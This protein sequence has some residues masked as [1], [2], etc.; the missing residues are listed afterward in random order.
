MRDT[1]VDMSVHPFLRGS[2]ADHYPGD[3]SPSSRPPVAPLL[4]AVLVI[5]MGVVLFR[6]RRDNATMRAEVDHGTQAFVFGASLPALPV[7]DLSSGGGTE[8]TLNTFCS[9]GHYVLAVFR[10]A[11]CPRCEELDAS[12]REIAARRKDA[13]VVVI[14]VRDSTEV[15]D[16]QPRPISD[17]VTTRGALH[18]SLHIGVLPAAILVDNQC[19]EIAAA[20]GVHGATAVVAQLGVDA[21]E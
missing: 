4:L 3:A 17:A 20:V 5:A 10:P 8:R 19:H 13:T 7:L 9:A 6:A 18:G 15:R 16:P 12:Y 2:M 1:V 21:K 11:S 14:S